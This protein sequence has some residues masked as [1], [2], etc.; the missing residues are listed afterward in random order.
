MKEANRRKNNI[1]MVYVVIA[2][3]GEME[4]RSREP[5]IRRKMKEVVGCVQ[6]VVGNIIS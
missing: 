1:G 4:E 6:Y 2:K 5:I 3:L